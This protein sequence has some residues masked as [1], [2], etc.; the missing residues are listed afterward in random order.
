M[1]KEL[2]PRI[3]RDIVPNPHCLNLNVNTPISTDYIESFHLPLRESSE[4]YIE[5]V[6]SV[7]GELVRKINEIMGCTSI[8]LQQYSVQVIVG[9][10]FDLDQDGIADQVIE[11]LKDCF[12][13]KRDQV[14]VER[15]DERHLYRRSMMDDDFGFGGPSFTRDFGGGPSDEDIDNLRSDID[16]LDREIGDEPARLGPDEVENALG[17]DIQQEEPV[18][19][20][21]ETEEAKTVN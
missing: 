5:K 2:T 7:G 19:P 9:K 16:E 15:S 21:G 8:S 12:G 11:A 18:E 6:G 14:L 17:D 20:Q 3:I 10:A 1:T 4:K 13:D